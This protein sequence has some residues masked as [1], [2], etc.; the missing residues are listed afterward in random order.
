MPKD[1]IELFLKTHCI[2]Y[3]GPEKQNGGKTY[4]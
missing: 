2:R 3:H 1:V 4:E